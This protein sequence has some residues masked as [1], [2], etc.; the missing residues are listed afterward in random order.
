MPLRE[1]VVLLGDSL[2]E[3]GDFSGLSG[4][5]RPCGAAGPVNHGVSGDTT[6]GILAR[7]HETTLL[8]P[9]WVFVQA[10]IND[11]AHGSKPAEL[12]GRLARIWAGVALDSPGTMVGVLNLLPL[13]G[14]RLGYPASLL[15]NSL[16]RRANEIIQETA[17]RNQTEFLDLYAAYA[18]QSGE[19]PESCTLDGL[20]LLP[21][22]YG[23]WTDLLLRA[24][25]KGNAVAPS[26]GELEPARDCA[27]G[28]A[29]EGADS[30]SGGIGGSGAGRE[31]PG[32]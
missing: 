7:L 11:L 13:C 20:H 5:L 21:D 31:T 29:A 12:A 14:A 3:W 6:W 24:L 8:N 32:A 17:F 27:W 15:S 2:T 22:A 16:V 4:R 25:G 30:V 28:D 23:P 9:A 1:T 18:D 10:G 19:L 26:P